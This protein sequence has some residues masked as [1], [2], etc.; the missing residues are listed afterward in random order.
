MVCLQVSF[1]QI[2]SV[3]KLCGLLIIFPYPAVSHVFQGPGPGF[4]VRSRVRIQ[5]PGSGS[6]VRGPVP[7]SGSRFQKQPS[8]TIQLQKW[9][10]VSLITYSCPN[11]PAKFDSDEISLCFISSPP[12]DV[13]N[14]DIFLTF[15]GGYRNEILT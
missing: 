14:P 13:R 6:R 12:E 1:Q 11:L 15:S 5:S 8:T 9:K 3:N 10:A 7:G 4:R 2:F